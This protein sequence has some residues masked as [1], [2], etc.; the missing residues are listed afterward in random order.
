ME[1]VNHCRRCGQPRQGIRLFCECGK[2]W[3]P[4]E[5]RGVRFSTDDSRGEALDEMYAG[6][7]AGRDEAQRDVQ[8]KFEADVYEHYST[9]FAA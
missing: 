7:E 6:V 2:V 9:Q 4:A 3:D 5:L 1:R 8:A